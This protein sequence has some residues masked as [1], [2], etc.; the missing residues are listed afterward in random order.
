MRATVETACLG[1][2][3]GKLLSKGVLLICLSD[4]LGAVPGRMLE[5]ARLLVCAVDENNFSFG[6]SICEQIEEKWSKERNPSISLKEWICFVGMAKA[7][8]KTLQRKKTGKGLH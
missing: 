1:A 8:F 4:R 5:E 2:E 3:E 6:L 7:H